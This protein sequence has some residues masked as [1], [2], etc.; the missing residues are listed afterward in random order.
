MDHDSINK[1]TN[2]QKITVITEH[3]NNSM[4]IH[5]DT[6]KRREIYFY[7]SILFIVVLFYHST[8]QSSYL[9]DALN[10]Y[11]EKNIGKGFITTPEIAHIFLWLLTFIVSTKYYQLNIELEKQYIYIH[12]LEKFINSCVFQGTSLFTRE[13]KSYRNLYRKFSKS[14][15]FIY[16]ISIPFLFLFL[17]LTSIT[18]QCSNTTKHDY[19][20]WMSFFIFLC[21]TVTSIIYIYSYHFEKK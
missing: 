16:T 12:E 10:A 6:I 4:S 15:W 8:Q 20:L 3:Y 11:T 21:F 2:E 13:S 9:V 1:I 14:T 17:A 19:S 5:K 7:T 18:S